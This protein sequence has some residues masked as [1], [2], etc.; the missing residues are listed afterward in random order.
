MLVFGALNSADFTEGDFTAA[1]QDSW[2]W[3]LTLLV[4]AIIGIAAQVRQQA[5]MRRTISETW[6]VETP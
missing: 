4:L 2:G 6:Y 3:W 1:V 5:L